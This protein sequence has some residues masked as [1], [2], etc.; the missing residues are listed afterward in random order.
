MQDVALKIQAIVERQFERMCT[1]LREPVVEAGADIERRIVRELHE[2]CAS[3]RPVTPADL[4]AIA[5]LLSQVQRARHLINRY[6]WPFERIL[7]DG[8]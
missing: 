1:E 6:S 7:R 4:E 3:K 2:E 8:A 5:A